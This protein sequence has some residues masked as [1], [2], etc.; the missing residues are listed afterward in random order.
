M[1]NNYLVKLDSE[2]S[3]PIFHRVITRQ[4]RATEIYIFAYCISTS[5]ST[6]I[7]KSTNGCLQLGLSPATSLVL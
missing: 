1:F 6:Y 7:H 5:A 3:E 4:H 2:N